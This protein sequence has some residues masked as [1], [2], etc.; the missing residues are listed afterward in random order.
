M[1]IGDFVSFPAVD[2]EVLSY[3]RTQDGFVTAMHDV[4]TD[5]MAP[6]VNPGSNLRQRSILR[7]VNMEAEPAKWTTGGYD[8][9]GNWHPMAGSMLVRAQHA[10]TITAQALENAHGL[11]DGQGKWRL[12][13]RGFPWFAMSLLENPTGHLTNLSTVPYNATPLEDGTTMYRLPLFPAAGGPREGFVRVI[14]R[15]YASGTVAI[16]AVDDAGNRYG[17]VQ[18]ALGRR[19]ALHFNSTDLEAGNAAKEL[20]AGIGVGE[21]DWRLEVTSKLDLMVL[22]YARTADGFLTSLHDVAPRTVDGDLWIPFFNPGT[23]LNQVSRLRL[24]N[25]G[26]ANA[27]ATITGIDDAGQLPGEVVRLTIPAGAAREL[28]RGRARKRRRIRVVRSPRRWAG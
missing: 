7:V 12:R 23:N 14:N 2:V 17:P 5:A 28:N 25:W 26:D 15:S 16:H 21:G 8:D 3:I 10:L 1:A 13:V 9:R 4:A 20:A 11:G 18:L 6:F 19:Q 24:V 27:T 22:S